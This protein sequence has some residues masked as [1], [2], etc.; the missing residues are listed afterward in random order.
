MIVAAVGGDPE[1]AF[2]LGPDVVLA[3][4]PS[5]TVASDPVAF[6]LQAGVHAWAAVGLP[7]LAMDRLDLRDQG[8]ILGR[9]GALRP[10]Q[11]V[12]EAAGRGIQNPAHWAHRKVFAMIFDELEF[13]FG[14]S[15][16][17]ATAFFKMS[18]SIRKRSFSRFSFR[19]SSCSTIIAAATVADGFTP[20]ARAWRAA[21]L[22]C[23]RRSN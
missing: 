10:P 8:L 16:K 6:G 1:L 12:V 20:G 21:N 3:H 7:T 13:H 9:P 18:R 11:P 14:I 2:G 19:I 5:H 23:Q 17:M 4:Q 22:R 15:E